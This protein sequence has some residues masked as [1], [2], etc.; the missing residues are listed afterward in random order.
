MMKNVTFVSNNDRVKQF[1]AS[2][3]ANSKIFSAQM[4]TGIVQVLNFH[5]HFVNCIKLSIN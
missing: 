5:S 2:K 3:T 1:Y 4:P